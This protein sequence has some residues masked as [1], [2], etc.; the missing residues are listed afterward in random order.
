MS[1]T[2]SIFGFITLLALICLAG[3][4][5]SGDSGADS[6]GGSAGL[7]SGTAV[8]PYIEGAVFQEIAADGVTVLQRQS[9]PSDAEGHFTFSKPLTEGS[10]V[11]LKIS[12]KGM[13]K[14]APFEG[15]LKRKVGSANSGIMVVSP[16]T[17][18]LANSLSEDEV[19]TILTDAGLELTA[20]ELYS[21]PMLKLDA[22]TD[23][24]KLLQANMAVNHFMT[25]TSLFNVK[26]SDLDHF[27]NAQLFSLLVKANQDLFNAAEFAR[28]SAELSNQTNGNN[29]LLL[30]DLL[31]SV[32]QTMRDI[33]VQAKAQYAEGSI[34]LDSLRAK[35][36]AAQQ[37]ATDNVQA[38][39]LARVG[40]ANPPTNV[41]GGQVF[42][43][44]CA[45]CH[46]LNSGGTMDLSGKGTTVIDKISTQHQGKNL[47]AD[48]LQALVAYVDSM[49][50]T[51]TPDPGPEP[52]ANGQTLYDTH[53]AG[54]HKLGEYDQAGTAPDL[55]GRE[56][57]VTGKI[58]AGH[59]GISFSTAEVTAVVD[60]VTLNP[61]IPVTNP[62]PDPT[63]NPTPDGVALYESECQG[64]H[65]PLSNNNIQDR[66][67][68]GIQQAI[69]ANLGDMS[70]LTLTPAEIQAIANNLPTP[71]PTPD[72]TP[73]P[74]D[75]QVLYDN[76]CASCHTMGGYD[77]NGYAPE[78][79]G[80]GNLV[81]TKLDAGHQGLNM[82]AAEK[83]AL[84]TWANANPVVIPD[85][86]PTPDPTPNPVNGQT[87]YDNSC[88]GC[89]SING[90]DAT[91]S[92]PDLASS[93]NQIAPKLAAGHN[94]FALTSEEE[95]AL[96]N[97][98]DQY[99]AA[100]SGPD[101]SDCT[102]CHAQPPNGSSF[103]NTA[104]SHA[105]HSTLPGVGNDCSACHIGAAHNNV[106][107]V[108]ITQDYDAKTGI[109]TAN[110]D[111]TCSTVSCHGGQITP[112]WFNGSIVVETQCTSC[113]RSGTGEFNGFFSGEHRKHVADK[114]YDCSVCHNTDK[115][116]NGHFSN[117]SSS[118]FELSPAD[119]IGG[120]STRV[121]SY[122]NGSC[123]SVQC[124]GSENW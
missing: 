58:N 37:S 16:L 24:F 77:V 28:I 41:D 5:G 93:G 7:F 121:G 92:A 1:K 87:V 42:T 64:C 50:T 108:E 14:G 97:F 81:V 12:L 51:P 85:P 72:P 46:N 96:A 110:A 60:W 59:R 38:L 31:T 18:L 76:N 53:C 35:I 21:D 10:F 34:D 48:Q 102:A 33:V 105:I 95:I 120:G 40:D 67:S 26:K 70:L 44:E 104:G 113:H 83:D 56:G 107:D 9:T 86:T 55:A 124:H 91:G 19:V 52:V 45:S 90:Y 94:G 27:D 61:S 13:H 3:C 43:T 75:G 89:H 36:T 63:P 22:Q 115:L 99:R 114:G 112:D 29:P 68:A 17:T 62:T 32:V 84:A 57:I 116:N 25:T 118:G 78:L 4:G 66:S 73:A 74:V 79:G 39:Y 119:T 122:A 103:P 117:L 20:E 98:L 109:A 101:Y 6:A 30:D 100:A 23:Q 123:S 65:G 47:A 82:T 54:C 69:D 11:E 2:K 49:A 71:T 80:Q 111:G 88:A 106:L 8:D 15:M